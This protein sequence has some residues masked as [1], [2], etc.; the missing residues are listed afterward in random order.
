MTAPPKVHES[1]PGFGTASDQLVFS[2]HES[3]TCRYGWLPKLHEAVADDPTIFESPERAILRL[4]IGRNMVKSIRFWADAFGLT[5]NRRGRTSLTEFAGRLLDPAN[6]RDPYLESQDSLWRL[7]WMLTVHGRLGAWAVAFL[8]THDREVLKERLIA[9]VTARAAELR[10]RVT[11][12]TAT[13]HVDIFLRTYAAT[14]RPGASDD[15][16]LAS[17]FQ[18]LALVT[19]GTRAGHPAVQFSRGPKPTLT[20]GAFAFAVRD[21]WHC[22]APASASL[23]VRSLMLG[24]CAPGLV[25]LLDEVGL[26]DNAERLCSQSSALALQPDGAGGFALTCHGDP[27]AELDRLAWQT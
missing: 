21:F 1:S 10:G 24:Y 27:L 20:T 8:D 5:T 4:G 23:S 2:G 25:Y 12:R 11:V 3:F 17:P 14:R 18:E 7:H 22:S 13:N 19:T 6:G 9:S 15:D 16:L 26:H